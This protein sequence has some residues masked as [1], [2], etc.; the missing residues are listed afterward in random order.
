MG[1]TGDPGH[2]GVAASAPAPEAMGI[3]L[4][5]N[6]RLGERLI[7]DGVIDEEQLV[8]A[9]D[10]QRQTGAFLGETLVGLGLVSPARLGAYLER[11]TGFPWVEL[12]DYPLNLAVAHSVPE[13]LARRKLLIPFDERGDEVLVAMADPLDLAALDDL[14]ARLDRPVAPHLALR[15]DVQAAINRAYDSRQKAQLVLEELTESRPD[16][17]P[18]VDELVGMAEDAP[19]VRLVNNIVQ[20]A[21]AAGASDIH[22][23]PQERRA[24]VRYRIDGLLYDQMAI[25]KQHQA[26][27]V[28]RIKIMS[29]LNIAERRRAQ[30]GRIAFRDASGNE[31]DLRVALMPMLYGEK[32]VIR[33]LEKT[34]ALDSLEKLGFLREQQTLYERLVGKPHG[35]V[36][37][38]G[39]TGSGKS[40]TLYA[41]LNRINVPTVNITTIEDPIEYHIEGVNQVQVNPKTGTTFASGLRSLVRQ[42]PDIIMVGEIRDAETAEIAVQAALTGHLVLSTL[43]TNDATS[44][45]VRLQNMGVEPY[46]LASTVIGCVAQRLVRTVC[47]QCRQWLPASGAVVE[48]LGLATASTTAP[49]SVASGKG[50]G[51][52]AG[53]GLRGRTAVFEVMPMTDPLRDLVLRR[54]S[55]T[56]LRAQAVA[57]G[58]LTMRDAAVRKVLDGV[59]TPD[60][61]ARVLLAED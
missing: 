54:S 39:P 50:C 23:E 55:N 46:L 15:S 34:S 11:A 20:G 6:V 4:N 7:A 43:H 30:D 1:S 8:E 58:M 44:A 14:R 9:L 13:H 59:T 19:I 38:T 51:R 2:F 56:D 24:R 21:L 40:T 35:I 57:E 52:C 12:A 33:I 32:A 17:E 45:L 25:P 26:A 47:P 27:V 16:A 37:V 31:Y 49:P 41:T 60:E 53:R 61:V 42:D 28:S 36:L 3:V 29:R 5:R 48:A 18:S 22:I 10:R